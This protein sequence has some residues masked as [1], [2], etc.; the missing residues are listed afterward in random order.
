VEGGAGD[1]RSDGRVWLIYGARQYAA[2]HD[3][4]VDVALEAIAGV[5][6]RL[7]ASEL[8]AEVAAVVGE[9]VAFVLEAGWQPAEVVRAVRRRTSGRHE[10]L[11]TTALADDRGWNPG[12]HTPPSAWTAQLRT[13]GVARWWGPG[14]DWLGP[15]STRTGTPWPDALRLVVEALGVLSVLPRIEPVLARPSAWGRPGGA[16]LGAVA[17]D[18]VLAKVRALL[19]KAE[20]TAFEAE[21]DALT[22]KA[23]QLM[24]RHAIDDA[25]ARS[26]RD[27]PAVR[28]SSRRTPVDD[29]YASAKSSLLHV[30]GRSNGVRTV[31]YPDLAL[32]ALIG[33][34]GD[35]DAVEVLYT[36]LL[37]QATK[38]MVARGRV[39]DHRGHSR[40]RSFRQSFLVSFAARIGERL[41][42][43]AIAARRDAEEELGVALLPVLAG[44]DEDVQRATDELFPRLRRASGPS[45]TNRDGW[46]AGRTAAE[47]A[48]LGPSGRLPAGRESA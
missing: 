27:G 37:V 10:D 41:Q 12:G 28:P 42:E 6:A 40:T 47:L 36:S 31:W 14:A 5:A 35:L 4:A 22:A 24:V 38:A 3:G 19:A 26:G 46:V 32:M 1:S 18:A 13:L 16:D 21:A 23:Q 17:D 44:R 48:D 34:D 20:S 33:F 8:G 39:T 15:W 7:G 29:P 9:V 11:L 30:V 2:G 43:A 25:L 45:V